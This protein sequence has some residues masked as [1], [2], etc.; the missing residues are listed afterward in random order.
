MKDLCIYCGEELVLW[1][2]SRSYCSTC[3]D[4]TEVTYADDAYYADDELRHDD[5]Y[6]D[7]VHEEFRYRHKY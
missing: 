5:Y 6:I 7:D 3:K 4:R 2:R 1:E